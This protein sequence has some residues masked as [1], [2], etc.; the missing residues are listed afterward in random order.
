MG[1]NLKVRNSLSKDRVILDGSYVNFE[2]K[3]I[4]C[5]KFTYGKDLSLSDRPA[6]YQ[7]VGKVM[8]YQG[9]DA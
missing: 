7:L 2:Q 5:L 1:T 6:Q 9:N 4:L 8:A 3:I